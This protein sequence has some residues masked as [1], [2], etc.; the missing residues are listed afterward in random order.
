MKDWDKEQMERYFDT[1]KLLKQ[2]NKINPI[3]KKS[4]QK[5]KNSPLKTEMKKNRKKEHVRRILPLI[6]RAQHTH[7][8]L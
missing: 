4:P 2:L 1:T 7:A 3:E 8:N 6:R 5:Q